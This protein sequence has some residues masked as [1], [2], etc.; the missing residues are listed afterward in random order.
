M[1]RGNEASSRV[2]EAVSDRFGSTKR[3]TVTSPL[4][5]RLFPGKRNVLSVLG[6]GVN[7]LSMDVF[8]LALEPTFLEPD[9]QHLLVGTVVGRRFGG[10]DVAYVDIR[11][12]A[13][14]RARAATAR[15][16]AGEV[17]LAVIGDHL[18][19]LLDEEGIDSSL[20]AG[21]V[22]RYAI[23]TEVELRRV[24]GRPNPDA[25]ELHMAAR[26]RGIPTALIADS[27][28]PR[29]LIAEIVRNSGYSPDHVLI[30]S[31]E[32]VRK[33]S[34]LFERL[35]ARSGVAPEEVVHLG[36][37]QLLDVG[38]PAQ[39]GINGQLFPASGSE[40]RPEFVLG[41]NTPKGLGSIV[42][43]HARRHLG[44]S[45]RST[46]TGFD[47]G[48]Y[49]AGP[50]LVGFTVWLR[51][52]IYDVAPDHVIFC[53]ITGSLFDEALSIL[54]HDTT[55]PR[56]HV[57]APTAEDIC[58]AARLVATEPL[59]EASRIV[60]VGLGLFDAPHQE[61]ASA[62]RRTHPDR[63]GPEVTGAYVGRP[64]IGEQDSRSW[65]FS[66][67]DDCP[68]RSIMMRRPEIV[69]A[70]LRALPASIQDVPPNLRPYH[71]MG[72]EVARGALTFVH[73]VEPWLH[74]D[75]TSLSAAM[76]EP[77]L[78]VITDPTP[79]EARV[80]AP[81]PVHDPANP[82][83]GVVPL[84]PLPSRSVFASRATERTA[85]TSAAWTAGHDA[86]NGTR[87]AGPFRA[88]DSLRRLPEMRR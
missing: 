68:V 69:E 74:L 39:L 75:E 22:A 67:T 85:G 77:A 72:R 6:R 26:E 58:P 20:D 29:D 3:R 2:R 78:R 53:G 5:L 14:R 34:G 4:P 55:K 47:V 64:E 11:M 43:G 70:M 37:D 18:E 73:D 83:A 17:L 61:V 54:D 40:A 10:L 25:L 44:R 31:N 76:A 46:N 12:E 16:E 49:A 15:D 82:M 24:L 8:G 84:A 65:A 48:Y 60:V 38:V 35:L 79:T 45:E 7:L 21:A 52:M 36:P 81:Y 66:D 63:G 28:L 87:G 62:L 88:L 80:F 9:H 86:L 56:R 27:H 42:L 32:G 71:P 51:S 50:L 19:E 33:E 30:S 1:A 59:F 23:D 13:E 57:L 41:I